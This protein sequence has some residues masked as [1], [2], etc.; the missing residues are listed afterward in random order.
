MINQDHFS[1]LPPSTPLLCW[2]VVLPAY[3]TSALAHTYFTFSCSGIFG[4][5]DGIC[6]FD[7][8]YFP[9]I[10]FST[11]YLFEYEVIYFSSVY[12]LTLPIITPLNFLKMD[13]CIGF[14]N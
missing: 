1:I 5:F 7:G 9:G 3:T 2:S 6:F 4:S 8:I 14:V 12:V 13:P 10:L 11:H